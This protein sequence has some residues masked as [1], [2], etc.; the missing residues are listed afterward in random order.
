MALQAQ[1]E[2][3]AKLVVVEQ[4]E[5]PSDRGRFKRGDQLSSRS[6]NYSSVPGLVGVYKKAVKSFNS[7]LS[8]AEAEAI[9]SSIIEFS[10]RYEVDPRLVVAVILT[11]SRFRPEATSRKGA[12]G[13]GQLMPR[14]A[15]G[16]GVGDAYDPVENIGGSVKLIKGHLDKLSGNAPWSELSWQDLALALASY[17]AGPGA[18]KKHGGIPP[19]RETQNYIKKVIST[20]RAL[21]GE[22]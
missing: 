2:K 14:T 8:D 20:Y 13:L 3:K 15:K 10:A 16:L 6:G 5:T 22:Q 12:M 11:E 19:Y 1:A 9:A 7:K 17:N 4:S 21:C 18:V